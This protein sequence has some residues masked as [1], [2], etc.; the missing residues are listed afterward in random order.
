MFCAT[1]TYPV[2]YNTQG[3]KS[4]KA[5]TVRT[6]NQLYC[7]LFVW[8]LERES[9]NSRQKCNKNQSWFKVVLHIAEKWEVCACWW[10]SRSP[11]Y[12]NTQ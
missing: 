5:P 6:A 9:S 4:V 10:D 1:A 12:Y 7:N 11:Y 2:L 8:F 3:P